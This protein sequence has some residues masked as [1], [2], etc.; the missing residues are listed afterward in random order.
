MGA[1]LLL[2]VAI[3]HV[4]TAES[5]SFNFECDTSSPFIMDP[6][7]HKTFGYVTQF[8]GV[9]LASAFPK[10]LTVSVPWNGG[11]PPPNLP[12]VKAP[13]SSVPVNT[14]S[15]VGVIEKLI[16]DGGVG[17][18]IEIDFYVSQE[19]AVQIKTLQQSVLKTTT[20]KTLQWWIA[21]YDQQQKIWYEAAYPLQPRVLTGLINPN[22]DVDLTPFLV[23]DGV[24]VDVYKIAIKV[25]PGA[26]M[27]SQ[28]Q[29]QTSAS[30]PLVK[31]WGLTVGTL[32][33]ASAVAM[34]AAAPHP[35]PPIT[36][37][38]SEA[39]EE[40]EEDVDSEA[41]EEESVDDEEATEEDA[42]EEAEEEDVEGE[43]AE[44]EEEDA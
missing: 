28:L 33:S 5:V 24:D 25:A 38:L 23:K 29:F 7:E 30:K 34:T 20:I 40:E 44:T 26:N 6:N 11:A 27:E 10:D 32:A 14:V 19:N 3:L 8:N 13:T 42:E 4:A 37:M 15:V 39:E 2:L 1:R 31:Q 21:S 9:G 22:L 36:A 17:D 18:P 41:E 35:P 16:W 43:E 12:G